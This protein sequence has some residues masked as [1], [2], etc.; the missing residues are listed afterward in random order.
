M[1]MFGATTVVVFVCIV[2]DTK[3]RK[4]A[5]PTAG[6]ELP[7]AIQTPAA[8]V[9]AAIVIIRTETFEPT[10]TAIRALQSSKCPI[11]SINGRLKTFVVSEEESLSPKTRAMIKGLPV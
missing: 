6:H 7:I 4:L 5:K 3:Y 1:H 9:V 8:T 2:N 10:A 11:N